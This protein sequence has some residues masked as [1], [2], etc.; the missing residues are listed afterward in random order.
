MNDCYFCFHPIFYVFQDNEI[1]LDIDQ[2]EYPR[3]N[4]TFKQAYQE[5]WSEYYKCLR[6]RYAEINS[7][8]TFY[9]IAMMALEGTSIKYKN[10][11]QMINVYKIN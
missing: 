9:P 10:A 11:Y 1:F 5:Q 4:K 7:E 6:D 8:R 3:V 2:V